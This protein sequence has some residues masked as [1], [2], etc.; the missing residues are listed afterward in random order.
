MP[1]DKMLTDLTDQVILVTDFH[2]YYDHWFGRRAVASLGNIP[3]IWRRSD[4]VGVDLNRIQALRYMQELGL[5]VP[6][7]AVDSEGITQLLIDHGAVVVHDDLNAHQGRGK[8]LITR[9]DD[10]SHED[11]PLAVRYVSP[12]RHPDGPRAESFRLLG[13][14]D[15]RFGLYYY[16]TGGDWRSNVA[17]IREEVVIETFPYSILPKPARQDFA[18]FAI[19]YVWCDVQ[20][21]FL[22]ID[23]N[24]APQLKGTPIEMAMVASGIAEA[25]AEWSIA[26]HSAALAAVEWRVLDREEGV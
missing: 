10:W 23:F 24:T 1:T 3:T 15:L 13:A 11:W 14:G 25:L 8:R 12:S 5:V 18:L 17:T 20:E 19:D 7:Y 9:D 21:K 26:H 2:D 22:A 4:G 6:A 16:S